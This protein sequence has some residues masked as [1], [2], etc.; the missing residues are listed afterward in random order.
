MK[1]YIAF[2]I[3]LKIL[4]LFGLGGI[5][6]SANKTT[7]ISKGYNNDLVEFHLWL[8]KNNYTEY[9]TENG[10]IALDVK[11]YKGRWAQPY[12]S[13]PNRDTLIYYH[14]KNTWSHTNGDRNTYQFGSYKVLPNNKHEFIFDVTPNAFIQKQMNTKA[15]LSYLYYDNG[16]IKIDEISPKHRFGDFIDNNT[17][18]RSNSMGKSMVSLVLG[19]AICEGYID[20]L[21]ST[22]SDWPMMTNTLYYD[23]KLIALGVDGIIT[24]YPDIISK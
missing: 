3:T 4:L 22:M 18:L 10:D 9:L 23:K 6:N 11:P 21:N 16:K 24:D 8:K 5:A 2:I 12:H 17:D 14:Y 13:N 19:T 15:I 20:G 1:K 7:K